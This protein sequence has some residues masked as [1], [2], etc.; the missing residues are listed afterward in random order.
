METTA[1]AAIYTT[2]FSEV[3]VPPEIEMPV[4]P[5]TCMALEDALVPVFLIEPFFI[6]KFAAFI[7]SME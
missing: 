7:I 4:V 3:M 1:P 2:C 6:T 5:C